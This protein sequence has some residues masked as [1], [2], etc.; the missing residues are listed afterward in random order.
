MKVWT[1]GCFD[2][3]H[4]GHIELFKFCKNLAGS[5]GEVIIGLDSDE[6]VKKDKGNDRPINSLDDRMTILRSIIFIDKVI[7]FD[8]A[9]ELEQTIKWI[10]PHI[11]VIGSDWKGKEVIG[12]KWAE[13]LMFFNRIGDY[14]TTKILNIN[15]GVDP[16]LQTR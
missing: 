7:P 2:I 10:K 11:M 12:E 6:K 15:K 13:K 3:I 9:E 1:N 4:R 8:T 5:D 14:S 16:Y